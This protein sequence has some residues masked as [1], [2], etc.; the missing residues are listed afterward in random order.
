MSLIDTVMRRLAERR[1][2]FH[3]EAEFQ[4]AFAQELALTMPAAEIRLEYRPWP[5]E[6]IYLDVWARIGGRPLAIELKYLTRRL[7]VDVAGEQFTLTHQAAHDIRRHDFWLDVARL[8]RLANHHPDLSAYAICLTNDPSYWSAPRRP[9]TIDAAF[10]VHDGRGVAGR[11]AW[12][13]L[14][15]A[16]APPAAGTC[17]SRSAGSTRWAG[18]TTPTSAASGCAIAVAAQPATVTQPLQDPPPNDPDPEP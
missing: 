18:P 4:F 17:R 7:D 8:E 1:P 14:R 15:R 12:G 3:S 5:G 11:L 13:A 6:R 9:G 2:V 10:R 16:W